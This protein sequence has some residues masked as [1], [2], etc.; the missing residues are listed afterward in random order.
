MPAS[1]VNITFDTRVFPEYGLVA[2]AYRIALERHTGKVGIF[3]LDCNKYDEYDAACVAIA[4]ALEH[5]YEE[6]SNQNVFNYN[7]T[8]HSEYGQG[9]WNVL[10]EKKQQAYSIIFAKLNPEERTIRMGLT[11]PGNSP[12]RN[13]TYVAAIKGLTDIH[14]DA[15]LADTHPHQWFRM[16]K[17]QTECYGPLTAI[18][19]PATDALRDNSM[20]ME[21]MKNETP[22]IWHVVN[23]A[24]QYNDSRNRAEQLQ[25]T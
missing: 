16:Q 18:G 1:E 24:M 22:E 21:N 10:A 8:V 25:T 6:L 19:T 3:S 2:G 15:A 5:V 20:E 9:L 17:V 11:R 7:V 13:H 12:L 14:L 4:T 23:T